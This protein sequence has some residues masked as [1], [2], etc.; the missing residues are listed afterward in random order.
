M[1]IKTGLLHLVKAGRDA[2]HIEK[3]LKDIGYNETPYFNLY[4]EICNA[5]YALLNEETDTFDESETYA[6]MHDIFTSDEICAE[7]LASICNQSVE[8]LE[9]NIPD[10]T[11]EI[12]VESAQ[13][14]GME[15]N[16]L[17]NLILSEWAM[18]QIM[19]GIYYVK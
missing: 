11:K 5:I 19:S 18:K 12:L 2:M 10:A 4:G 7:K 1:D 9:S 16:Q 15:L 13:A 8:V 3:T 14:K 6:A 17:I